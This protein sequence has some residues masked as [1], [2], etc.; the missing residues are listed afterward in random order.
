MPRCDVAMTVVS[1]I[2][3]FAPTDRCRSYSLGRGRATA[4]AMAAASAVAI[5]RGR[6]AGK[7]VRDPGDRGGCAVVSREPLANAGHQI[8]ANPA[9]RLAQPRHVSLRHGWVNEAIGF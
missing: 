2:A 3:D 6:C 8:K 7:S 1:P 4:G 9:S 5:V